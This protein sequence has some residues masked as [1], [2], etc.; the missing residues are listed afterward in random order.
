[1]RRARSSGGS[2][3]NICRSF[4]SLASASAK[5]RATSSATGGAFSVP[6]LWSFGR[7]IV[8]PWCVRRIR[9]IIR[10]RYSH[11]EKSHAAPRASRH[12]PEKDAHS[13]PLG[14][15]RQRHLEG[16]CSRSR[17]RGGGA[18]HHDRVAEAA[19]VSVGS[20]YQY[21]PNKQA[22]LYR[23][24]IEEWEKTG[25]T[26]DAILGD[27]TQSPAQ[28]LRA[29]I[30]AFFHSECEE[31]PLRLALDAA[32]PSY[33]DAPE[34][35]TGRRRSRR[36]VST[37]VAAAAPHA[38]ARQR[39]FAAELVFMTTTAVGKQLS[40]GDR[41]KAEIERWADA[42]AEMLSTYLARL[43]PHASVGATRWA[44]IGR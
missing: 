23:L 31:A 13:G 32:A 25:A 43:G 38:T 36:I 6:W 39:S 5:S 22:I 4:A 3:P 37:F 12:R 1:M 21:F 14:P 7:F 41:S 28:C 34:A 33:H 19:G 10:F 26:I 16:R 8:A 9:I 44:S 40:E 29:M 18:L 27:T 15:A 35:R 11:P 24:Q 30:R 42:I 17:A 20:L 2:A